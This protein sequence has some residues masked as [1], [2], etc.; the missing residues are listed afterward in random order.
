MTPKSPTTRSRRWGQ[1][2]RTGYRM[3][4]CMFALSAQTAGRTAILR[5]GSHLDDASGI[6]KTSYDSRFIPA[7][8]S[9]GRGDMSLGEQLR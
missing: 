7:D 4:N 2:R 5:E 6:V 8:G 3:G 9:P 1:T